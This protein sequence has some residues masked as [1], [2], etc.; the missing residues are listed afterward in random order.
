LLIPAAADLSAA[1]DPPA[2]AELVVTTTVARPAEKVPPL[3]P[4]GWGGCGAVEWAANNFV[5]NAGNE[6][7]YWRN[8]HRVKDCGPGWFEIDGPG[9]SWWDLWASGFLSGASLRIYRLVDK[10]G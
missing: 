4:N 2:P 3:G 9:T 8:L 6:P 10:D 1:A 7:V 5:R